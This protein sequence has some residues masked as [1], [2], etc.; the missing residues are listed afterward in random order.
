M[1]RLLAFLF[2]ALSAP[3]ALAEEPAINGLVGDVSLVL[4]CDTAEQVDAIIAARQI[5]SEEGQEAYDDLNKPGTGVFANEPACVIGDGI[6]QVAIISVE[7]R[8]QIVVDGEAHDVWLVGVERR[9]ADGSINFFL[10]WSDAT[11]IRYGPD[12]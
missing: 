3:Y 4:A 10:L 6:V 11:S 9:Y 8:G 2:V 12:A 7:P 5:G 1:Q